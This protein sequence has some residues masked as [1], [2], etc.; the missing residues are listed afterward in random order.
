MQK[1]KILVMGIG[2]I[3]LTDD[4]FGVHI[5]KELLKL[6]EKNEFRNDIDIIDGGAAGIDILYYIEDQD[7]VIFIDTI[8]G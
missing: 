5:A 2:N 7:I 8:K 4:G 6:Q 3:L 1:N